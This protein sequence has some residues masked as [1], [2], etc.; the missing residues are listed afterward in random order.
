MRAK[1]GGRMS[2][3]SAAYAAVIMDFVMPRMDGSTATRRLRW[4]RRS[5]PASAHS[6][7]YHIYHPYYQEHTTCWPALLPPITPISPIS[8]ITV[9]VGPAE[10]SRVAFTHIPPITHNSTYRPLLPTAPLPTLCY[11]LPSKGAR[12]HGAHRRT[13][14]QRAGQRQGILHAGA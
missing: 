12:I 3:P 1:T 5:P 9:R 14:G 7:P 2:D 10:P 4:A 8:P 6:R 13:D 11:V